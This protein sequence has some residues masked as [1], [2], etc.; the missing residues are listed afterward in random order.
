MSARIY[1]AEKG[2][3]LAEAA[4]VLPILLLIIMAALTFGMMIYVK[5]LVVLSSSQAAR[6]GSS[7]Y[8]DDTMTAEEKTQKIKTTAYYYL[9]SGI[10]G[11]DR[12]VDI[13]SDGATI[14]VKVTYNYKL[15]FPLLHEILG[16]KTTIPIQY[17]SKFLIQ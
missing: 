12:K 2:Q 5:T 14:S 6:V 3:A 10:S 8:Y 1:K 11:T 4:L 16:N 7:I 9:G 17:E 13:Y 15:I